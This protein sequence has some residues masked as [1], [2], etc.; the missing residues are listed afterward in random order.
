MAHLQSSFFLNNTT[1]SLEKSN[2]G[3]IRIFYTKIQ[4]QGILQSAVK[5][6]QESLLKVGKRDTLIVFNVLV[7]SFF[8]G[9]KHFLPSAKQSLLYWC[10]WDFEFSQWGLKMITT[11]SEKWQWLPGLVCLMLKRSASFFFGFNFKLNQGR[12]ATFRYQQT[13]YAY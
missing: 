9:K 8:I 1:F 12:E 6:N 11:I 5:S 13:Q 4:L 7:F 3:E 2:S 10:Q